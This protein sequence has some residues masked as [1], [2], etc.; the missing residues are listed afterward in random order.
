MS[1]KIYL[2]KKIMTSIIIVLLSIFIPFKGVIKGEIL[3]GFPLKFLSLRPNSL[4]S[5]PHEYTSILQLVTINLLTFCIDILL[6]Y[7]SISILE[8]VVAKLHGNKNN[9]EVANISKHL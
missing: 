6:V 1:N 2:S 4:L 7:L 8:K 9:N 5:I 3:L